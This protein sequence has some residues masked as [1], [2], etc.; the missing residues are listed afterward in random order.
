MSFAHLL[1][2]KRIANLDE[3]QDDSF[4]VRV[5][6][7]SEDQFVGSPV[8]DVD[9]SRSANENWNS[10][11][12]ATKAH[13]SPPLD[14]MIAKKSRSKRGGA[15]GK[16]SISDDNAINI[17]LEEDAETE[18]AQDHLEQKII[19]SVSTN[20]ANE[21]DFCSFRH[22]MDQ[23]FVNMA[24]EEDNHNIASD[25]LSFP[26]D[27]E[28]HKA[29]GPSPWK[30]GDI[31]LLDITIPGED[32]RNNSSPICDIC[33]SNGLF[34]DRDSLEH[35][36]HAVVGNVCGGSYENVFTR[37]NKIR[38]PSSSSGQFITSCQA[39]IRSRGSALVENNLGVWNNGKSALVSRSEVFTSSPTCSISKGASALMD[40]KRQKIG[41]A[42]SR[43]CPKP[44]QVSRRK[45]GDGAGTG[46]TQRQRPRDRQMIQDRVKEL[47]EMVPSGAKCSIDALLD[48]TVK[49]MLFLQSVMNQAS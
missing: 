38:S 4:K 45:A 2:Y 26:V 25:T 27:S 8:V 12:V 32:K 47:R 48:R 30:G 43:K 7:F 19:R 28:L 16:L 24:T 42:Q 10:G 9:A 20:L 6:L 5:S 13:I 15:D 18:K 33:E 1:W 21:Y 41:Y 22:A 31:G 14:G 29:L 11:V 49:H 46:D 17:I 44:Y 3:K 35:L 39:E 40:E 34:L 37:S 36:L 23:M